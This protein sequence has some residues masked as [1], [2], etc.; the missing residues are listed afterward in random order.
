MVSPMLHVACLNHFQNEPSCLLRYHFNLQPFTESQHFLVNTF[1][2]E[3]FSLVTRSDNSHIA[4]GLL[5]NI[6]KVNRFDSW[7]RR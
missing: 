3:V 2:W 1:D 5:Q 4:F 7:I 6:I